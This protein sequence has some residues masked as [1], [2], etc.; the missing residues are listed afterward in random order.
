MTSSTVWCATALRQR[1]FYYTYHT[2]YKSTDGSAIGRATMELIHTTSELERNFIR[3]E[4]LTEDTKEKYV[5]TDIQ[6]LHRQTT[7]SL[8]LALWRKL[9][10]FFNDKEEK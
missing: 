8:G 2:M 3:A 5:A 9:N 4:E 7:L 1:L 10:D 6:D